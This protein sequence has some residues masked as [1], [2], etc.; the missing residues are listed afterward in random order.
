MHYFSYSD[1]FIKDCQEWPYNF[2]TKKG[3]VDEKILL[4]VFKMA[5]Q[6]AGSALKVG[7]VG[8][9]ETEVFLGLNQMSIQKPDTG[10]E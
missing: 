2:L 6:I 10:I 8:L 9:V 1:I 4:F 7:S 5:L 3:S